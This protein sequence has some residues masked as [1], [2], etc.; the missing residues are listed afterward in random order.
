VIADA[1]RG[2]KLTIV[3]IN[4]LCRKGSDGKYV[5]DDFYRP[6]TLAMLACGGPT[7]MRFGLHL[8][9][10]YDLQVISLQT[11]EVKDTM[12]WKYR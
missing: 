7:G 6:G 9:G 4:S 5:G 11:R 1:I 8:H 12:C 3:V 10:I 2:G